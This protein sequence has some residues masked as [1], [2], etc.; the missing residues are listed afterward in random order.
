MNT[1]DPADNPGTEQAGGTPPADQEPTQHIAE[2]LAERLLMAAGENQWY[3]TEGAKPEDLAKVQEHLELHN[4]ERQSRGES[5]LVF[6]VS[7]DET[8]CRLVSEPVRTDELNHIAA[9]P[10]L[11]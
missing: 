11:Y 1:E 4:T 3:P 8:K 7:E 9:P 6:V 5:K 10:P 2:N